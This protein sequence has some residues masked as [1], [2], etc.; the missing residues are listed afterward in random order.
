MCYAV[1]EKHTSHKAGARLD[2]AP[3]SCILWCDSCSGCW[4]NR[5]KAW[6]RAASHWSQGQRQISGCCLCPSSAINHSFN[7]SIVQSVNQPTSQSGNQFT[8]PAMPGCG[9]CHSSAINCSSNQSITRSI[10][11]SINSYSFIAQCSRVRH[12][13][14]H[15]G[16]TQASCVALSTFYCQCLPHQTPYEHV[17]KWHLVNVCCID[18]SQ[19]LKL[20]LIDLVSCLHAVQY[21]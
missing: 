10:N 3:L 1:F 7:Q 18:A 2:A 8:N 14:V 16:N 9:L 15:F 20:Q 19:H 13:G 5:Y 17:V 6:R 21:A 4:G 11:R 12:T